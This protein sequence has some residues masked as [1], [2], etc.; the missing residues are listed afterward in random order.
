MSNNTLEYERAAQLYFKQNPTIVQK[1]YSPTLLKTLV[2]AMQQSLPTVVTARLAFDRLVAN[3]TLQRTDGKSDRDDAQ[4]N[5]SRAQKHLD[6]TVAKVDAAP[7]T[8]SELEHFG[9]LSQ[10]ELSKLYYGP[11]G[12][13]VCEFAVRYRKAVR[14][15][16][17]VVP[18]KF[19]DQASVDGEIQLSAAEYHALPASVL[20]QRIRDPKWKAAVYRL[21]K[22]GQ[23]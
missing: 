13:A 14:E 9:S 16:G 6:E 10:R 20:K 5:V 8:P 1:Y 23:I 15:F 18:P 22:A 3:G 21:I 11:D 4:T 17:F 7:L 2:D 19:G 12:D